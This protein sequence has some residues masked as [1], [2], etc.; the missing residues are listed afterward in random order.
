MKVGTHAV[1]LVGRN[2]E[3]NRQQARLLAEESTPFRENIYWIESDGRSVKDKVIEELLERL[4]YKP[5]T[6]DMNVAV[7]DNADTMT[8]RAQNRLLKTLEEPAGKVLIIL[9]TSNE[10]NLLPT[11]RSRCVIYKLEDGNSTNEIS[12]SGMATAKDLVDKKPYF[13]FSEVLKEAG[14]DR[15][16]A[17]KFADDL[18]LALKEILF[19]TGKYE[20]AHRIISIIED[21]ENDIKRHI[22]QDFALKNMIVKILEENS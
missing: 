18:K 15:M 22:K 5:L 12:E 1:M 21:A 20:E 2:P 19:K 11:V 6:G 13:H 14:A 9:L 4:S 3:Y 7:I 16:E 17:M 10:E 8:E